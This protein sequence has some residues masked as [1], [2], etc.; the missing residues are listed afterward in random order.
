MLRTLSF[1][2]LCLIGWA[3]AQYDPPITVV[4]RLDE[5]PAELARRVIPANSDW[6]LPPKVVELGAY[7]GVLLA[8]HDA[9]GYCIWYLAD[10]PGESRYRVLRLR[11]PEEKDDFFD[12]T[13]RSVF[14]LGPDKSKDL[15][16]LETHQQPEIGGGEPLL[17]GS[18]YRV[19]AGGATQLEA[20]SERLDGVEDIEAA[21]QRLRA[22]LEPIP[23]PPKGALVEAFMDI[24]VG[25]LDLTSRERAGLVQPGSARLMVLDRGNGYLQVAGDAGLPGY[26]V[27]M[28]SRDEAPP[29]FAFQAIYPMT[30]FTYFLTRNKDGWQDISQSIVPGY[31][32]ELNYDLPRYGTEVDV[33]GGEARYSL[34]W[35]GRAFNRKD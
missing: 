11:D 8:F 26:K 15:V 27:V 16:T 13:I 34:E 21:T 3:W 18:V 25:F 24:P 33:T 32:I 1:V 29:L 6:L 12:L 20:A 7:S 2:C 17:K 19:V 4:K 28:F 22:V 23:E 14:T 35:T 10:V 31:D 9:P 5:T 30:Q